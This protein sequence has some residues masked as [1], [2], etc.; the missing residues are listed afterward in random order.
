[1]TKL[2]DSDLPLDLAQI[3]D[4]RRDVAAE[5]VDGD[6]VADLQAQFAGLFR[7]EGDQRFAAVIL[8]PTT[9]PRSA[10]AFSGRASA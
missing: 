5:H 6:G 10:S 8:R 7:R 9:C 2:I 3:G 1:M 4:L